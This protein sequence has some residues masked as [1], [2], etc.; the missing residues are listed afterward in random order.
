MI[1]KRTASW[2]WHD[3]GFFIVVVIFFATVITAAIH[4][5]APTSG[6]EKGLHNAGQAVGH[7]LQLIAA[8]FT[9]IASWFLQ[10]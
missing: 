1:S 6:F 4:T 7:F 9:M 5:F 2:K 8:F 3:W 10:L